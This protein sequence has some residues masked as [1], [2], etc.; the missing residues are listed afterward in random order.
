MTKQNTYK[1]IA[2]YL[3]K[4][5]SLYEYVV[6][7]ILI[8]YS[9]NVWCIPPSSMLDD[10][11]DNDSPIQQTLSKRLKKTQQP[12]TNKILLEDFDVGIL[13]SF[14]DF[15]DEETTSSINMS[16]ER[17]KNLPDS[18]WK[19]KLKTEFGLTLESFSP[20]RVYPWQDIYLFFVKDTLSEK[21]T[22]KYMRHTLTWH[23]LDVIYGYMQI[24]PE[25]KMLMTQYYH[26]KPYFTALQQ[27]LDGFSTPHISSLKV[28]GI[29]ITAGCLL[30]MCE[31]Y[32]EKFQ[33]IQTLQLKNNNLSAF[34]I[35]KHTFHNLIRLNVWE[36]PIQNLTVTNIGFPM[37]KFFDV[38]DNL[39]MQTC[40]IMNQNFPNMMKLVFRN[41]KLL[42]QL[43]TSRVTSP[44]FK[45]I[46]LTGTPL[47]KYKQ[48][49]ENDI[50]TGKSIHIS[51]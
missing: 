17:I 22:D 11:H 14:I 46:D 33:Y 43:I 20:L 18:V 25:L 44:K 4:S 2:A 40:T 36:N 16:Y 39:K 37:L 19:R 7:F 51:T 24:Y 12:R 34:Y 5:S 35:P 50:K 26:K 42:G 1:W 49:I 15:L 6:F 28:N 31:A 27:L 8:F 47:E 3:Q 23:D 30:W 41:N 29:P 13:G 9:G 10:A 48:T 45:K 38:A 21:K 32:K